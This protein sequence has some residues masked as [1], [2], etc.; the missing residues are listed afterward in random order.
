LIQDKAL[1]VIDQNFDRSAP[2]ASKNEQGSPHRIGLE[3]LAAERGQ[4]IDS[5]SKVH[6][7]HRQ[8]DAHLRSDLDHGLGLQNA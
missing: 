7:L 3:L 4:A 5:S 2:T 1:P 6:R 8:P